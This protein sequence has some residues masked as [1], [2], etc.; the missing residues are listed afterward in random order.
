MTKL[1]SGHQ[2]VSS[3]SSQKNKYLQTISVTL[4]VETWILVATHRLDVVDICAKLF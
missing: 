4:K 3:N 1:R 2:C